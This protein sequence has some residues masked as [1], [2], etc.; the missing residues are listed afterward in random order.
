MEYK[1]YNNEEWQAEE[2]QPKQSV[3]DNQ[4][5]KRFKILTITAYVLAAA[6]V[7]ENAFLFAQKILFID[8]IMT[9]IFLSIAEIMVL[10]LCLVLMRAYRLIDSH[11]SYRDFGVVIGFEMFFCIVQWLLCSFGIGD[12]LYWALA[13]ITVGFA[14]FAA[15]RFKS[16]MWFRV[17]SCVLSL[18]LVF[19]LYFVYGRNV[20]FTAKSVYVSTVGYNIIDD[21]E[22]VIHYPKPLTQ[23]EM[24]DVLSLTETLAYQRTKIDSTEGISYLNDIFKYT[25]PLVKTIDSD[26]RYSNDFFE[27]YALFFSVTELENPDDL[28]VCT[29]LQ[30][31]FRYSKQIFNYSKSS[32]A[33]DA[34]TKALCITVF[35]IPL[36]EEKVIENLNASGFT[37]NRAYIKYSNQ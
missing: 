15:V 36:N 35:E 13:V 7:A 24:D 23:T 29:N 37:K 10:V 2:Y 25:F 34:N 14:V 11:L 5:Y 21:T 9:K 8:E 17:L 12:C 20:Q 26:N 4:I 27:N 31:S 30:C 28:L 3:K 6:A 33:A 18:L 32:T 22:N 19:T 16:K 1:F